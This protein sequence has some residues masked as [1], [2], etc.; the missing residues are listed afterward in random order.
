M[1][2]IKEARKYAK[3][4][5]EKCGKCNVKIA[6]LGTVSIQYFVMILRY[7]L[8]KEEIY[9]DI[10]EGEYNGIE[11]DVYDSQS[12]LY[13]FNPD[14]VI[15]LTHYL[16]VKTFPKLMDGKENIDK[17]IQKQVAYYQ[18]IWSMLEE[19]LGCKILQSNIVIPPEH[20]LGNLERQV[21]YSRTSYYSEINRCIATNSPEYVTV[22]DLDLMSNYIGK[23]EWFDYSAYFLNKTGVNLNCIDDYVEPFVKQIKLTYGKIRKCLVLDLDNTLWGGVV[24][25]E[26]TNGI[27]LDPNNAVGEAYRYF[28]SYLLSLKKR[29]VILAVCSKND[30]EIA[31]DPFLHNENMILSLDDIS[32]FIANWEDKATNIKRIASELNIGI[33]SLVFVDD[34]PAEREIVRRYLP[35]VHVVDVPLDPALYV[36]QIDYEAPFEWKQLTTEDLSRSNTYVENKKRIQLKEQFVNYKEYLKALEMKARVRLVM[37]DDIGRFTQLLNKSNQFNLRTQRYDKSAIKTLSE[38]EQTDCIYVKL[39]DKYSEYGIISCVIL[40]YADEK[41]FID[42]WVMSCR[43]LK[44]NVEY[45][46][47]SK[48][49]EL[50]RIHNCTYVEGEY[51]PTQKNSMVKDF[52]KSLGFCLL[53]ECNGTVKYK[54]DLTNEFDYENLIDIEEGE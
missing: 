45:V 17:L 24:G 14:I 54:Y 31:K 10:Y 34:N 49:I 27:G 26:G 20:C 4:Y 5:K 32:C 7:L 37:S 51:I 6:V 42:S 39:R 19:R 35:E 23:Y 8:S 29:G 13:Q 52:Y 22:V 2:L 15:V 47:F 40:R 43:V 21:L 44:R 9:A 16:D 41:C 28:Q 3:V 48:I 33:D 18:N 12:V 11:M 53:G 25:D 36:K 1:T 30:E 50:A 46:M 38:S